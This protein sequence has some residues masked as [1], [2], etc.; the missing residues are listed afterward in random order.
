MR[1][2]G[3]DNPTLVEQEG[4]LLA[5][6]VELTMQPQLHLQTALHVM[7][8]CFDAELEGQAAVR[9]GAWLSNVGE[10][11]ERRLWSHWAF[12]PVGASGLK[13]ESLKGILGNSTCVS[14]L[15]SV[16]TGSIACNPTLVYNC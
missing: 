11:G 15:D 16:K 1:G 13:R 8:T 12:L 3:G 10:G 5:P 14:P 2:T 7:S 4:H 9:L 6:L